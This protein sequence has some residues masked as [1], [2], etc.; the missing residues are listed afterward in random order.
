[1]S[2]YRFFKKDTV[3]S[4]IATFAYAAWFL[5]CRCK[6]VGMPK[7]QSVYSKGKVAVKIGVICDQMTLDDLRQECS[8]VAVTP[9]NWRTILMDMPPDLLLC[10]SAWYGPTGSGGSWRGR[11]YRNHHVLFEQRKVLFNILETC[12][13]QNIPTAFWCKEDP[14][15]FGDRQ[16]DFAD[17][18]L[19]FDYIFTTAKECI[20]R[21]QTLG[22]HHV[23]L[24]QFAFSPR[25]F[26][27]IGSGQ[28]RKEAFF[29]GSWYQNQAERCRDMDQLFQYV[30]RKG[31]PYIIYDKNLGSG[32]SSNR[33][34]E[35][36]KAR[37]RPSVPFAELSDKTKRYLYA[38]NVNTVK[39]SETMFSRRVYEMMAENHIII[40]THAK[41]LEKEFPDSVWYCDMEDP[42]EDILKQRR[43]NLEHVFQYHTCEKWLDTILHVLGIE[44][45]R[46]T[47]WLYVFSLDGK[48]AEYSQAP[49]LSGIHTEYRVFDQGCG[50]E[51][52]PVLDEDSY[53]VILREGREAQAMKWDFLLAQFSYLPAGCGVRCGKET[54]E[55]VEDENNWNCIFPVKVLGTRLEHFQRALKKIEL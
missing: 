16:H 48:W 39:V 46:P 7:E 42:P 37:I 34:P 30:E 44:V 15:Y 13:R 55:I 38:L 10:E 54:Y 29:A 19:H 53:A 51:E 5:Y 31:I 47:V 14:T 17:T 12:R 36:Y 21:Y 11:I 9:R 28:M 26:N 1:M 52:R 43:N 45:L 25:L 2:A 33:F 22:H 23:H 32:Q 49:E 6:A 4:L 8:I 50:L 40:S 20:P 18:A 24:L 3:N 35:R 41:G 27:P